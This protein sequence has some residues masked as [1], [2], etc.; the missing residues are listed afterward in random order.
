MDLPVWQWLPV[1]FFIVIQCSFIFAPWA[2]TFLSDVWGDRRVA[3]YFKIGLM[4]GVWQLFWLGIVPAFTPYWPLPWMPVIGGLTLSVGVVMVYYELPKDRRSAAS[5]KDM[6]MMFFTIG[7]CIFIFAIGCPLLYY[8][9]LNYDGFFKMCIFLSFF[10]LRAGFERIAKH[11]AKLYCIDCY[12]IIILFAMYAYEFFVASVISSVTQIWLAML[13]IALDLGENLYYIYCSYVRRSSGPGDIGKDTPDGP[14]SLEVRESDA[15]NIEK[16]DSKQPR[17]AWPPELPLVIA[18][19]STLSAVGGVKE[20]GLSFSRIVPSTDGSV[21]GNLE[22]TSGSNFPGL[23]QQVSAEL[24]VTVD[25]RSIPRRGSSMSTLSSFTNLPKSE[26]QEGEPTDNNGA[27]TTT[28]SGSHGGMSLFSSKSDPVGI[29]ENSNTNMGDDEIIQTDESIRRPLSIMT[30]AICK[31]VVEIL[32]PVHYLVCFV[33]LR[34]LNPKLHD[35][36]WDMTDEEFMRG[37]RRLL[38]DIVAE[39]GVFILLITFMKRWYHESIISIFL[40]LM[41]RFFWPFLTSQM[42]LMTYYIVLQYTNAGMTVP[43]DF[44]WI[45]EKNATWHGGNCYTVGNETIEEVC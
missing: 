25:R 13:L 17:D 19:P 45:G 26:L 5:R 24:P 29:V 3:K 44:M 23:E 9:S 14:A 34:S 10:L 41:Y 37:I 28:N 18:D 42:A 4:A 7:N 22:L 43:F 8:L 40:R 6:T 36:F 21:A 35:A 27:K 32:A 15:Q 11:Y 39:V 1:L 2:N 12:P 31:E 33:V 20:D 38:I 30:I 16:D